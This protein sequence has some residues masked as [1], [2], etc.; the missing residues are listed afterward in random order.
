MNAIH[1]TLSDEQLRIERSRYN[2]LVQSEI[3]QLNSDENYVKKNRNMIIFTV[4]TV[5]IPCWL[6][7]SKDSNL[8]W[9]INRLVGE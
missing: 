1:K 5:L 2:T 4:V 8:Y 6:S 7:S 3:L 9:I